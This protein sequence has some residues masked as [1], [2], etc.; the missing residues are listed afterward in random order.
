[1]QLRL[2]ITALTAVT[3]LSLFNSIV[4][5]APLSVESSSSLDAGSSRTQLDVQPSEEARVL[6]VP[7]LLNDTSK[8]VNV[9][10]ASRLIGQGTWYDPG[11]GAC[12]KTNKGSDMIVAVAASRYDSFPGATSNPNKNPIC[13]KKIKVTYNGKSVTVA[14][15]DRCVGCKMNDLDFSPGAFKKLAPL[16]KGRLNGI[17]WSYV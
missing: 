11:L 14:V 3:I 12:G 1:M 2:L 9:Q 4:S 5:A 8:L 17:T 10:A 16:S 6:E 13:K 15:V 7:T